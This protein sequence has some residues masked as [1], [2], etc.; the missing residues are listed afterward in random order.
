MLLFCRLFFVCLFGFVLFRRPWPVTLFIFFFISFI[1]TRVVQEPE[2]RGASGA[3]QPQRD[4]T[5]P[6]RHPATVHQHPLQPAL[7]QQVSARP[8]TEAL[9]SVMSHE[10]GSTTV[11]GTRLCH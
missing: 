4:G 3:R 5:C 10:P 1:P 8:C 6:A 11:T 7:H 2:L 9:R